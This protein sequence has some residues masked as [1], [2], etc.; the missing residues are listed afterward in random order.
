MFDNESNSKL[1]QFP[2]LI[3]SEEFE[4]DTEHKTAAYKDV[5]EDLSTGSTYKLPEEINFG[6]WY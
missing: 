1:Y 3:Y 4:G 5:R 6:N 2:K